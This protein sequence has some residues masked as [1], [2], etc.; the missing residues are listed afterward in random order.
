MILLKSREEPTLKDIYLEGL[1]LCA[2]TYSG[3]ADKIIEDTERY[4]SFV[5]EIE[6]KNLKANS[7]NIIFED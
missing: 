4:N 1:K 6:A 3:L 7:R 5:R 2:E